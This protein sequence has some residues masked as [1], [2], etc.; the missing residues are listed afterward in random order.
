MYSNLFSTPFFVEQVDLSKIELEEA[1]LNNSFPSGLKT[2]FHAKTKFKEESEEYLKKILAKN[3]DKLGVPYTIE[4]I[5]GWKNV[6]KKN[7]WQDPHFHSF[8]QFSFIIYTGVEHSNTVFM[9]PN[10]QIIESQCPMLKNYFRNYFKPDLV[11]G[12]MVIFPSFIEHYVVSGNVGETVA[13]NVY[14]R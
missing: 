6:Y 12:D 11:K 2:T 1:K 13:G 9:N 10:R 8:S 7:D 4:E 3:L 14:I 5:I